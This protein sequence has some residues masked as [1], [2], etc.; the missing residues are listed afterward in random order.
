MICDKK[1]IA[2]H[3]NNIRQKAGPRYTPE[4]NVDLPISEIFDGIS[5]TAKFYATIREN[6]GE[7]FREFRHVTSKYEDAKLQNAYDKIKKDIESLIKLLENIKDYDTSRIP[8]DN[9][10]NYTRVL[11]DKAL[12]FTDQLR[13]AKT[14]AKD[15][16]IPPEKDGSY[17][18]SA[19]EQFNSDIHHIYKTQ[20]M[21][22]Y[23]ATLSSSVKAQLSNLPL[24]LL[25]GSAGT[26]KTHLLC[27][28]TEQ[29]MN[30]GKDILPALLAFGEV[31]TDE[32][33]FWMQILEQFE[34]KSTI[35]TKEEFLSKLDDLG[36]KAKC[37]SLLIID[38]LNE[39]ITH[40]PEFWQNNLNGIIR[41]VHKYPN[42]ALI[43]SVRSG[44]EDEV[45]TEQQKHLFVQEEHHGFRFREWE[46][47]NKFFKAFSLP[48]P[49]IPLLV[50][51]FQNP[52]FLLLFCKAFEKRKNKKKKQIFRGHEG[53]TYIFE[54][55]ILNATEI[56][57]K[58]FQVQKDRFKSPAYRIWSEIIKEIASE[59]VN[60]NDE[61]IPEEKLKDLIQTAYPQVNIGKFVQA[62]ESNMLVVKVPRYIKGK[63][64]S[65]F[66]IR[67]P[68]QK[69]SDHLIGRYIFKK[70][71]D[72]FGKSN[73]NL[74]TA[75]KFF[76][77]RRKLGNF[78][79]KTRNRGIIEALS[80][81][82]PEQLK[83]V[84]FI[85]VAPYLM[86]K[87]YLAQIAQ[88]AF[89]ESLIW[90]NP[91]AFSKH[92]ANTLKIINENVIR[93]ES[94]HHQL[95]NAFLSV[96]PIP[97][98]PFNAEC[99]NQHLSKVLMPK[100]DAWWSSFLHYQHG[101]QGAV[102]RLLQWSWSDQEKSHINDKSIFL[103]SIA[104][105]WFLT[106]PNKFLRDKATKGL[107][108][109]LQ[110]RIHLLPQL[111]EK[112]KNINDTYI[113]ERLFAVAYGCVLR[114]QNDT[115][116]LKVLAE[117]IYKN[118]F[119]ENRPPTHILLRDY[120]RGVIETALRRGVKLG[121]EED[122]ITPP[123]ESQ[124][125]EN[126]PTEKELRQRYYP[127]DFSKNKTGERG[128]LDIWFSVMGFGDFAKLIIGTSMSKWTGNKFGE[129][130]IDK[131]RVF[132][133]FR[134]DLSARQKQLWEETN[135][136]I[137]EKETTSRSLESAGT[138]IHS[139]FAKSRKA[140]DE[141]DKATEEFKNSLNQEQKKLYENDIEPFLDHNQNI[142]NPA[143]NF[144]LRI[145]Q[146]WIFDRVVELGYDPKLHGEFDKYVNPHISHGKERRSHRIGTKY[147]WLAYHEFMAMVSDHFEF[148]GNSWRDSDEKFK[149]PWNSYSRDID[150]SFILQNDEHI[151]TSATF[152]L[153]QSSHGHYDAWEKAQSDTDWIRIENDLP[154]P[155]QIIQISD[156]KKNEWLMLEGLVKWEEQ[157]PPEHKQYDIPVR[158][159]WYIIK[160]Y[161]VKKKNAEKFFD[162]AKNQESMVRWM[163][164]SHSFY[165]AFLGE[166]PNSTAFEDLRGDYNIWT[167]SG[168]GN[169]DLQI[170]VVVTDDSYLNEFALDCSLSGSVS[171]KLP[172][173]WLVNKMDLRHRHV[174]GRFFDKNGNLITLATSIF[175]ETLPSALLMDKQAL[176]DFLNKNGYAIFWALLGEKRL[177]G[178]SLSREGFVGR[179]EISGV[180]TMNKKG[181][182]IGSYYA[183]FTS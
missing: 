4:L 100:R 93:T 31:F 122:K 141:I 155:E 171:V 165:E 67:F 121:I 162:W 131:D 59:M 151:K 119:K 11:Q 110:D 50:P 166:Y 174:D 79:S 28:L 129:E 23:F 183:K 14:Q 158:E 138:R 173:K 128:F 10:Q 92:G 68:F 180:Y 29:R 32:N 135:P 45:L 149:G 95:L 47:V 142:Y 140:K 161:I 170:P 130:L 30:K 83:C 148:K 58:A 107:V 150:P 22:H 176:I 179:L 49:E 169:E 88:E 139:K 98:H 51:E 126:I 86:Q 5:R 152:S 73:K 69:F 154:K 38:A 41:E 76:S 136:I 97:N 60:Q 123:Y 125:P 94:G 146:R 104:L 167:K 80:I 134:N 1:Y 153:W 175:E 75:R 144:D 181:K 56:I 120:A 9:I 66:D 15:R 53:A 55:F 117:W 156:D 99:L 71:E 62:L 96:A 87:Q 163:P 40:A 18:Q 90:R 112:F 63:R 24:L 81:Q 91:K 137:Y 172:C 17:Q 52:L 106:T 44:F 57:A 33:D 102:D 85:E 145:A 42:I 19:S 8:W 132:A 127:E 82:C 39:N 37:R 27:D 78:L 177:I 160:S 2:R 21:I 109:L 108:C 147:Q 178:G 143:K 164:E 34:I 72:E 12:K 84:E 35:T 114:N 103:T 54:S 13:K 74:K 64:E 65:C 46:A 77:K 7:L 115:K 61:R 89:V 3:L 48:L 6:Y 101:E 113:I 36:K 20:A 26:G 25:I 105:A 182:T 118:V 111:L 159:V 116:N 16:T 168:R 157:T 124:W 43:V 70:Y 133:E